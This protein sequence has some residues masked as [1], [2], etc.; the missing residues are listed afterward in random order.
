MKESKALIKLWDK[1]LLLHVTEKVLGL[2][3]EII[4]V[5]GKNHELEKYAAVLPSRVTL[6]KDPVDGKGPLLGILTG[7]KNMR[8]E[9]VL[10]LPCDVPFVRRDVL[11]RLLRKAQSVDAAIP[12]WPNGD[13]EPLQAVYRVSSA[14]PAAESALG[15]E[16]L[17]ILDMIKRLDKVV[18]VST[19]E[20][21]NF[22]P[23]LITFFN[24]NSREDLITAEK[25]VWL[26]PGA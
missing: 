4:V 17:L 14:L 8:S 3:H 26:Q 11:R 15:R 20:I 13:I 21:R 5:I 1:P 18:Y 10:V 24:I 2:T 9:Y 6:L 22:D 12:Q 23:E 16:E 19:D 7:M 25:M